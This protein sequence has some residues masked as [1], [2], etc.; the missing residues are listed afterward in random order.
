MATANITGR[1]ALATLVAVPALIAAFAIWGPFTTDSLPLFGGQATGVRSGWLPGFGTI[2]PNMG[3]TAYALGLRAALDLASGTLPLWNHYEGLGTPLLGEMQSAALFPPTLLLLLPHGQMLEQALLQAIAGVGTFLFLRRFGLGPA[4]ALAGGLIFE[5]NG[6]FAWL[7][8]AI[9]LPIA[10]LPWL[11]LAIEILFTSARAG[12]TLRERWPAIGLGAVAAALALIAGF[13][14]VVYFY[15]LLLLLWAV[16]R[17]VSL[18]PGRALAYAGDLAIMAVLAA[19]IASPSL[20]AFAHFLPEAELGGH[21]DDLFKGATLPP[22]ALILYW[23]PYF[24]GPVAASTNPDIRTIW[25]GI[26]GY[27]GLMPLILGVFGLIAG[28]RRPMCWL[29]AAWAAAAIGVSHDAPGL[30]AAFLH[31]PLATIA[32]YARYL[33]ASWILCFAVLAAVGLELWPSLSRRERVLIGAITL[34]VVIAVVGAGLAASAPIIVDVW[35][36]KQHQRLYVII[37]LAVAASLLAAF[38]AALGRPQ[39]RAG[40]ILCLGLEAVAAFIMPILSFPRIAGMD[41]TL[42]DF[43]QQHAGA[44]R[45]ALANFTGL[46][47]NYGSIFRIPAINYDDLPAPARTVDYIHAAIDPAASTIDF[48]PDGRPET[49]AEREQRR[50]LFVSHLP[51][52]AQAGVR[53][54]LGDA[55]LFATPAYEQ[56]GGPTPIA[57]EPGQSMQVTVDTAPGDLQLRGVLVRVGTYGGTADGALRVRLCQADACAEGR[58]DLATTADNR[59]V[60]I[61]FQAPLAL[62]AAPYAITLAHEGGTHRVALWSQ[63]VR[64]RPPGPLPEL[65]L[66]QLS[67]PAPVL[68]TPIATIFE[69]PT[70]RPYASADGC[71]IDLLSQD[72]MRSRCDHPSRLV[73]LEVFMNGWRALVNGAPT[74]VQ[75]AE[76]TFQSIDLPA[77]ESTIDF[78]YA[79]T[80]LRASLLVATGTLLF[81]AIM[82]LSLRLTRRQDAP[83]PTS[84]DR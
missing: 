21:K 64:G 58:L 17:A 12:R 43:L 2:D 63:D 33:N 24:Y 27:L 42:I 62:H 60:A 67:D 77:D 82:L 9:F 40:L 68:S 29:L 31:L 75:L 50:R 41:R 26:G 81:V 44:Q 7:R 38:T 49:A 73:R 8:N 23:L 55:D 37:S 78:T 71:Q 69:L 59:A 1:S 18:R 28:R 32:A 79:P 52:Y 30:H 22:A 20:I 39:A 25:G 4:A 54:V 36:S 51:G 56:Q 46:T 3:Y 35:P 45:T 13:P 34:A 11:F 14:E 70:F 48:R 65:A 19:L 83:P 61:D 57:L 10:F 84:N 72:R 53:Y 80:G 6:A 15:S 5:L 66:L 74:P 47:P 76:S 16:A